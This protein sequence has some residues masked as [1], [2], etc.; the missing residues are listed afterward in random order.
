MRRAT[1][2]LPVVLLA[3]LAPHA[4]PYASAALPT[5]AYA[6]PSDASPEPEEKEWA[7]ATALESAKP[8]MNMSLWHPEVRVTC[9][10]R[11][12]R[13]WMRITCTPSHDGKEDAFF[14]VVWGMAGELDSV[15]AS[16]TMA[17]D[18][19]RY[20]EPPTDEIGR[21]TRKM[22]ASATVTF[23]LRTGNAFV[24]ALDPIGWNETYDGWTAAMRPGLL[25]DVSW[26]RGE[27]APTITFR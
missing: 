6:W 5:A 23:Q 21:L 26:A 9:T 17:S 24:L 27:K 22:G 15:K 10:Q 19:E 7:K 4:P 11:V 3:P 20:R 18:L 1:L 16:F 12:L 25:L 8:T 2:I 13:E 14:G